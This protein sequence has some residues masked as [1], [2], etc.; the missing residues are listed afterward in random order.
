MASLLNG[1]T[2]C[3]A[4]AVAAGDES[5]CEEEAKLYDD[6]SH[7]MVTMVMTILAINIHVSDEEDD[8]CAYDVFC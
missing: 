2:W 5:I 7:I 8:R 4:T 6:G 3:N 1:S